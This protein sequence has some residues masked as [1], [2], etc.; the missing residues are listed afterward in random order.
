[1]TPALTLSKQEK[2]YWPI[3]TAKSSSNW[4]EVDTLLASQ[5]CR[6]LASAEQLAGLPY[7][8]VLL[9]EMCR[10]IHHA[11]RLL[12]LKREP[13]TESPQHEILQAILEAV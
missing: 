7:G 4:N 2:Q 10:R 1:M 6:D 13:V 9:P 8:E 12:K 5:M 11:A 3:L